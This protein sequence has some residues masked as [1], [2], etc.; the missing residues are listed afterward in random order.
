MDGNR[1]PGTKAVFGRDLS[2]AVPTVRRT[3]PRERED[4]MYTYE[5][6]ALSFTVTDT[7]DRTRD[8]QDQDADGPSGPKD[9]RM[10][11]QHEPEDLPPAMEVL[12]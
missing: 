4:R 11:S 6:V 8:H 12:P 3:R 5:G 1:H 2:A 9:R 10:C 7:S